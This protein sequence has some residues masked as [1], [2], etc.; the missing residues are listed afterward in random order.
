MHILLIDDHA[1]F[2]KSLE[3]VLRDYESIDKLY[4]VNN[5]DMARKYIKDESPDIILMDINLG[6]IS[7]ENGIT[8]GKNIMDDFNGIKVVFLTGFDLP[9]Y[10]YEA[11][12]MGARGFV[13]KNIEP[14]K[15]VEILNNINQGYVFFP[16][17]DYVEELT[18]SEKQILQLLGEGYIRK[19]I[20]E[21][22]YLSE[23]T[24]SNHL[25]HIFSKLEVSSSVEAV[26][27]AIRLGYINPNNQ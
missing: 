8:F 13:N 10:R 22:Q 21:K 2:A 24:V 26:T 4:S 14:D 3:A 20:A 16:G 19:Q 11:K 17:A 25:Q 1:L 9:V 6:N 27:K 15:L 23:R 12:K 18:E 5:L 7:D